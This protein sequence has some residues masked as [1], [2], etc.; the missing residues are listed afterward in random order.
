LRLTVT[1]RRAW[2]L[3]EYLRLTLTQHTMLVVLQCGCG[4]QLDLC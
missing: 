4:R 1:L 3:C 2:R